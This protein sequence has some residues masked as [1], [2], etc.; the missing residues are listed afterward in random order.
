MLKVPAAI[1]IMVNASTFWRPY[2][3]PSGPNTSP[4]RGRTRKATVKVAKVAIS[5]AVGLLP[6]KNTWP[7]VTA[8]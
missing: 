1:R 6:G 4:P 7:R 8:R 2:L 3:S 5:C